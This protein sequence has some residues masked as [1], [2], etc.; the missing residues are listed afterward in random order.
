MGGKGGKA[1]GMGDAKIT[2]K[3]THVQGVLLTDG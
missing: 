1:D 3:T 2:V